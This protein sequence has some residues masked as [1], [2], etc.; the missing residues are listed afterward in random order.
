MPRLLSP[1][2]YI[3]RNDEDVTLVVA[4]AELSLAEKHGRLHLC[5]GGRRN[6][7][8]VFAQNRCQET[9]RSALDRRQFVFPVLHLD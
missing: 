1:V 4:V 6:R 3:L 9:A 5:A 7:G 2:C 8:E